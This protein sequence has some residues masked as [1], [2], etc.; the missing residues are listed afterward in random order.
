M[1][2]VIYSIFTVLLNAMKNTKTLLLLLISLSL[3]ACKSKEQESAELVAQNFMEWYTRT[4]LDLLENKWYRDPELYSKFPTLH[5]EDIYPLI[6]KMDNIRLFNP[7]LEL[8]HKAFNDAYYLPVKAFKITNS[9]ENNSVINVFIDIESADQSPNHQ[10]CLTFDKD[11]LVKN[12]EKTKI[13]SSKGLINY[14]DSK[15][16]LYYPEYFTN[17]QNKTDQ[18]IRSLIENLR[19]VHNHK[20]I[21]IDQGTLYYKDY[22]HLKGYS[23]IDNLSNLSLTDL[24]LVITYYSNE[25]AIGDDDIIDIEIYPINVIVKQGENRISWVLYNNNAKSFKVTLDYNYGS[26]KDYIV[27]KTKIQMGLDSE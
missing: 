22:K 8:P 19:E 5:I 16:F 18:E 25:I 6:S 9:S 14:V 21:F 20:D 13:K 7:S 15:Y 2:F 10:I 27:S 17:F 12:K 4:G 24:R 1:P 26:L 11:S 23:I 3:Y